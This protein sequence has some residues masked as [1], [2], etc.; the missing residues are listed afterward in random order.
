MAYQ[1]ASK[2]LAQPVRELLQPA[3]VDLEPGDLP[4]KSPVKH[5]SR[6]SGSKGQVCAPECMPVCSR[7]I[8][9]P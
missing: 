3:V 9:K 6:P 7:F 8:E 5:W 4:R 1:S 2:I